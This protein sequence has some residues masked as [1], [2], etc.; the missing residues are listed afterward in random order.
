M[1]IS[2]S[3]V[4]IQDAEFYEVL[5]KKPYEKLDRLKNRFNNCLATFSTVD[6]T[7]HKHRRAAL[8]PFFSQK[9][10][11]EYSP[12]IANHVER[13][14]ERFATEYAGRHRPL[15][16]N[17]VWGCLTSDTVV[18]Y[19]FEREY[20]FIEEPDFKS[21]FPQAMTDLVDGVHLVTQFSWLSLVFQSLPD[22]L[23][24]AIQPSMKSVISFNNVRIVNL[25]EQS[26]SLIVR[27][28]KWQVKS[29]MC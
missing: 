26:R 21:R 23:V 19:C 29:P 9:K 17:D 28:S 16:L 10:I 8:N 25:L 18:G 22:W 7:L 6:Y 24:G 11:A 5:Y 13:L 1:R 4:H 14:C 3:E 2:P 27:S 15:V 20:H 12:V